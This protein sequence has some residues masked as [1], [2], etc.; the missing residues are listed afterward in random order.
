[1]NEIN[2]ISLSQDHFQMILV[3]LKFISSNSKIKMID[4]KYIIFEADLKQFL[5]KKAVL[6]IDLKNSLIK[7][8]SYILSSFDKAI[9]IYQKEMNSVILTKRQ[10]CTLVKPIVSKA[11]HPSANQ[12]LNQFFT[13]FDC[14]TEENDFFIEIL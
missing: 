7:N 1:M 10:I 8:F 4:E 2:S 14:L 9:L 6:P 13:N 11:A 12:N 3:I 5:L